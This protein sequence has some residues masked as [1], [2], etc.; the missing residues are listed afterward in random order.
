MQLCSGFGHEVDA[1]S[2]LKTNHET[3]RSRQFRELL[4]ADG[5]IYAELVKNRS[6]EFPYGLMNWRK[7]DGTGSPKVL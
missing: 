1:D 6:F 3:E 7:L 2:G 4:G 5:G